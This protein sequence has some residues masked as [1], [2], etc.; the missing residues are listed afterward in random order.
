MLK[1]VPEV[2]RMQKRAV[3]RLGL[4]GGLHAILPNQLDK[5]I[6]KKEFLL[7]IGFVI[8]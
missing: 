2:C 8:C 3:P 6:I 7:V 4:E 5:K 1:I